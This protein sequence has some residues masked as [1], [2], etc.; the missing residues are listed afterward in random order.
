MGLHLFTFHSDHNG[1]QELRILCA[2]E[3]GGVT[4]R[5]YARINQSTSVEGEG[6]EVLWTSKLHAETSVSLV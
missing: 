1:T 2:Y 3:N 4:L 5:K 6:W